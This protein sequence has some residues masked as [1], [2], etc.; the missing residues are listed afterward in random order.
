M[1]DTLDY[2]TKMNVYNVAYY[3]SGT[4]LTGSYKGMRYSIVKGEEN[5][6]IATTYPEPYSFDV[7]AEEL[8]TN[9]EFPL[10]TE[11]I[12]EARQWLNQQYEEKEW[13]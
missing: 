11:G 6:L 5:K 13:C 10:T 3:Q 9:K 12:E 1:S 7:T 8:K 2:I 4:R